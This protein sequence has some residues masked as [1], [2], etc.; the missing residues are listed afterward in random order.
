[1]VIVIYSTAGQNDQTHFQENK[2]GVICAA[3][4]VP[5]QVVSC[6]LVLLPYGLARKLYALQRCE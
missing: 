1:M 4:E 5:E 3:K 6:R 2:E